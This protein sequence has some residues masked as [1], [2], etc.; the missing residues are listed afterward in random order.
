MDSQTP[1]QLH[2]TFLPY[3]TPGHMN[4]MIDTARLFAKYGVS[5]TIITTPANASTFQKAIDTDFSSGFH[6]RTHVIPFPAAKVGLPDGVENIKDGTTIEKLG[7][8]MHGISMLKDQ[9]ELQFQDLQPDCIVSDMMYPWTVESAAKLGIPRIFF[10]SSSYFSNCAS[11]LIRKHS[12]HESLAS[13]TDKFTIPG[14]PQRIEMTP[15]Q[16]D[17]WIRTKSPISG[18]FEVIFESESR[19]YG[20]LYNSF[21]ELESEYEQLHESEVQGIKSWSIGPVSA[22][23]KKNGEQK[24]L[25]EEAEWLKWLNSMKNDSVLYVSFG[26]L[27]RLSYAQLVELAHGLEN[28]GHSFIWVVRKM[29]G[30]ENEDSF[31]QDFEQ[32][33]KESKKGYIIWNWAPQLL[34]LNHPAIGGIVTHCGWNSILESVS[35]GLPMI[36]WPMFGE[37]FYNEKLLV[38]VLKIAVPVG[39]KE[40]KFWGRGEK[41]AMMGR[42]EIAK[43]VVQ[44]MGKEENKEMKRRATKFGEDSKKAIEECGSSHNN[45][46]QFLDQLK[47]LKMSRALEKT[48]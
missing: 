11:N 3:P 19:S 20:S 40:N 5:V 2:V 16:L 37:Q 22:W 46:M 13:Y 31:L 32:R 14:L 7:K 8:I 9:I 47:S 23:V 33:M 36:A 12:P 24:D 48:N 1:Q 18:H 15:L 42:E 26:S 34:I 29:D 21:H 39:A 4:P 28:S 44:L 45:L 35:A 25:P 38:D 43:A 6:I 10:Y 41:D 27:T 17:E 30:K